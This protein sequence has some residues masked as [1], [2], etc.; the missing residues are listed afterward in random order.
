LT[1]S[2]KNG[3]NLVA[4]PKQRGKTPV[5]SGS[6]L[7]VCPALLASNN[8]LAICNDLFELCPAGLSNIKMPLIA[9]PRRFFATAY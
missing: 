4:S 8:R 2:I 6:K 3:E 7:P 1:E 5:A 9:R